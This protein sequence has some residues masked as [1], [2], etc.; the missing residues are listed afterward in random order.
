M[1]LLA[2]ACQTA[3]TWLA[4]QF[5]GSTKAAVQVAIA[6]HV[7]GMSRTK[8]C[9]VELTPSIQASKHADGLC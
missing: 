6:S 4:M 2:E 1:Q 9:S 7:A 5:P 3:Y 8:L